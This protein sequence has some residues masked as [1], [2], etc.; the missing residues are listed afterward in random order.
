MMQFRIQDFRSPRPRAMSRWGVFSRR[1]AVAIAVCGVL[2]CVRAFAQPEQGQMPPASVVVSQVVGVKQASSETFIGTV[3][4]IRKSVVGSAVGGRVAEVFVEEGQHVG[5][6]SETSEFD[7]S[8]LGDPIVRLRTTT[9]DM[10]IE[11]A[12]VELKLRQLA[13]EELKISL[14]NDIEKAASDVAEITSRLTYTR[15][16]FERHQQLFQTKGVS[17]KEMQEAASTFYSQ[18]ELLVSANATLRKLQS[19]QQLR[20]DQ[21]DADV[22]NQEAEIRRLLELKENYTVRAPFDGYVVSKLAEMG[23]W[24]A[25]GQAVAELV[26]LDPIELVVNVP[27]SSIQTVQS[28]LD[29]QGQTSQKS[30]VQVSI[31]SID[32]LFEGELTQI[33][34]QADLR[35][36][37]FPVKVRLTNP[38]LGDR[39]LIKAGMLGKASFLVGDEAEIMMVKKDALVLG[40]QIVVFVAVTDPA[41]NK[42]VAKPV[43]VTVGGAV[44]EWIQVTGLLHN[45]DKVV[46]QG[47]ERLLP[48]QA[49]AI[50]SEQTDVPP[51]SNTELSPDGT[52]QASQ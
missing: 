38:K 15:S 36:R 41:A 3:M 16:D 50:L 21:A 5:I 4:P 7:G 51:G 24:V 14:P 43:N 10:E 37:A 27:Q 34:P 46:V 13:A 26:Q 39:H 30:P 22:R 47:N 8:P 23:Q 28:L 32:Q 44:G 49:L 12:R 29:R 1:I 42:T 11:A 31:D 6:G 18:S 25:P 35:S 48:G 45:G 2:P 33:V 40:P 9:L 19:T 17:E 52:P 20:L